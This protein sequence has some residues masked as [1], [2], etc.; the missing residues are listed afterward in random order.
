MSLKNVNEEQL[1]EL[2]K[3]NHSIGGVLK[4]LGMAP[5]GSNYKSF[6]AKI[7]KW[8]IDN[9]HFTGRG[10]LK[11]KTH[12]YTAKIPLEKIL[13]ENSL[14]QAT[15]RLSKRLVKEK[16]LE[17]KCSE[18]DINTWKNKDLSLHLDH[19][20]GINTDNRIEN[21]RLLCPN[22]HSQTETYC[23]KNKKKFPEAKFKTKREYSFQES[24]C[25]D[26]D[27]AV[28]RTSQR[29][30]DCEHKTR[31]GKMFGFKIPDA[32][33]KEW[34]DLYVKNN[35]N[36]TQTSRTLQISDTALRKHFKK[37]NMI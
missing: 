15:S 3:K 28:Y 1:R 17:Y 7:K 23:G 25:I 34:F 16:I 31:K 12:T 13:I 37:R 22:C 2:V 35:K 19:I 6:K 29:C 33:V 36:M 30:K 4:D 18:C 8:N 32:T 14:Y 27:A 24:K 11:G 26:C 10:H 21:L 20:N 5:D 9:S